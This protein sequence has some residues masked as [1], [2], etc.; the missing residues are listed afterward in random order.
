MASSQNIFPGFDHLA[1]RRRFPPY[2]TKQEPRPTAPA[3]VPE[4]DDYN[5]EQL[6]AVHAC[7]SKSCLVVS[8]AGTGKTK[9]IVGRYAHLIRSGVRPENIVTVAFNREAADEIASRIQTAT[10]VLPVLNGTFHALGRRLLSRM[11][12]H[13]GWRSLPAVIDDGSEPR[14]LRDIISSLSLSR[15]AD[16]ETALNAIHAWQNAAVTP[17]QAA[18]RL[19]GRRR[20]RGAA[21][22][23]LDVERALSK[24]Y[25]AYDKH[26]RKT[27]VIDFGDMLLLPVRALRENEQLRIS[28]AARI[29]HVL[30]DEF[31]DI[32]DVQ[33]EFIHL[34]ASEGARLFCVGDDTQAIY[35]WREARVEHLLNFMRDHPDALRVDLITNYRSTPEIIALANAVA[36]GIGRRL[37]DRN[38]VSA[39]SSGETPIAASF[40][41]R[42]DEASAIAS[43]IQALIKA[44]N[45]ASSL[46][47]IARIN[48]S[49]RVIEERL[50]K[51]RIPYS[52]RGGSFWDRPEIVDLLGYLEAV[53]D[54][55]SQ[56]ALRRIANAP[57][58]FIGRKHLG[59]LFDIAA[60][61]K[62]HPQDLS[63]LPQLKG[64]SGGRLRSLIKN[65]DR[66]RQ[67]IAKGLPVA[68]VLSSIVTETEY[69]RHWRKDP[70][71]IIERMENVIELIDACRGF[72]TIPEILA[73]IRETRANARPE[74]DRN[75]VV[76]STIHRSKGLEWGCVFLMACENAT[77]PH[78]KATSTAEFDEERRLFYVAVTRASDTLYISFADQPSGASPYFAEVSEFLDFRRGFGKR[79][80][81]PEKVRS[82]TRP[83]WATVLGISPDATLEEIK[84]AF[85]AKVFEVHP[86]T[87]G[88]TEAFVPLHTAFLAA[89]AWRAS[90]PIVSEIKEPRERRVKR[91]SFGRGKKVS[92]S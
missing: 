41:S 67:D 49:L 1:P 8:G 37:E 56:D 74:T 86:D 77:M 59:E 82:R 60:G 22:D 55:A 57:M 14:I 46:A 75:A 3:L 85:N 15:L 52:V 73:H 35:G 26:K 92:S 76:L 71:T 40:A 19:Q 6:Q 53:A 63:I 34:L 9:T 87:G 44:G 78:A 27:K 10:G 5:E 38:L 68:T 2:R 66:W 51:A 11:L 4:S 91:R 50:S 83:Q 29:T 69:I 43:K 33:Y 48:R 12:D 17:E 81:K 84:K 42:N 28:F 61:L 31:Q 80:R 72:A 13:F 79:R 20:K 88:S 89:R 47:V 23:T 36:S 90:N 30:V 7:Q 58:R 65:I 39:R 18:E 45:P 32:N 64:P 25:A 70:E 62:T 16:P 21:E 24:I 54:P